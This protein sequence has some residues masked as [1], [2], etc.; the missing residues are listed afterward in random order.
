MSDKILVTGAAGQIGSELTL[1]LREKFG[2]KNVIAL[3]HRTK[4]SLELEFSGP[5]E[6][7]DATDKKVLKDIIKKHSVTQIY[8]LVG[9]LSAKGESD[10]QLAW[11]VNMESLKHVLDL[12]VEFKLKR[13]FW[14]SS[15]AVFGPTTPLDNTPQH[16]ILEPNTM[17]GI[18]KVAGEGLCNYY[19]HKYGL[20]VRSVRYPGLIS[21]KTPPGGGTTDY[22]V[23]I[24]YEGLKKK[25]YTCFVNEKTMLPMSTLR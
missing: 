20:D 24:F 2:S 10:P 5:F 4:P 13:I 9:V 21:H 17:Y 16:T 25:K 6:K 23:A 8:H 19:F 15:I 14:P 11:K 12:G 3:V 7:G 18:T 1:A 22:A